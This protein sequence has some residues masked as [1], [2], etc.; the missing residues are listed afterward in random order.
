MRQGLARDQIRPRGQYLS[1]AN[2]KPIDLPA[3]KAIQGSTER[4]EFS[5][6]IWPSCF[7]KSSQFNRILGYASNVSPSPASTAP[8]T[9]VV[10]TLLTER[11]DSKDYPFRVSIG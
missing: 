4:H 8:S 9:G 2:W 11:I 3:L 10:A 6:Q 1:T 7:A 5:R